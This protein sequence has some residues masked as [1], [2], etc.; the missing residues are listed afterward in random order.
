MKN[1]NTTSPINGKVSDP[2]E[3]TLIEVTMDE[4]KNTTANHE[5]CILLIKQVPRKISKQLLEFLS[6][7]PEIIQK[8]LNDL[9]SITDS[10]SSI[11]IRKGE[12]QTTLNHPHTPEYYAKQLC[13]LSAETDKYGGVSVLTQRKHTYINENKTHTELVGGEENIKKI[14]S[15]LI[16]FV[17]ATKGLSFRDNTNLTTTEENE[18]IKQM[19]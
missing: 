16:N 15:L 18:Q 19:Y 7:S 2:T 12:K 17:R 11:S 5:K 8:Q 4:N 3:S 1:N 14:R 13:L 10:S 6:Q 9:K